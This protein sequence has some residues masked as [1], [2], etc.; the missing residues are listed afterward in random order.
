MNE[1]YICKYC[2]NMNLELLEKQGYYND[3]GVCPVCGKTTIDPREATN[4]EY[5]TWQKIQ[6]MKTEIAFYKYLDALR[7]AD[8][9]NEDKLKIIKQIDDGLAELKRLRESLDSKST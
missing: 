5:V 7:K 9:N 4:E 6:I 8:L 2:G 3:F 1:H